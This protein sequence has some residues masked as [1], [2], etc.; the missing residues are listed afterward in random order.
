MKKISTIF[1]LLA[2]FGNSFGQVFLTSQKRVNDKSDIQS[3]GVLDISGSI[4]SSNYY[5]KG[6]TL[7]LIFTLNVNSPDQEYVDQIVMT[8]PQGVKPNSGTDPFPGVDSQANPENLSIN[9]QKVTWGDNDNSYGGI[10]AP[11]NYSFFVNVTVDTNIVGTIEI[12]YSVSGDQYK[13]TIHKFTGIVKVK[14]LPETAELKTTITGFISE[15]YQV[16]LEQATFAP[17]AQILNIGNTLSDTITFF[18][19]ADSEYADSTIINF[20]INTSDTKEFAFSDFTA[21]KKGDVT[22]TFSNNYTK[23]ANPSVKPVEKTINVDNILARDNGDI[24]GHTGIGSEGGE[25]G[26]VFTITKQDTLTAVQFALGTRATLGNVIS[27]KVRSFENG[28]P[29][30]EIGKSLPIKIVE[31]TMYNAGIFPAVVLAPGKYYIGVVEGEKNINIATTSTSFVPHTAWAYFQDKWNDVGDLGFHHTYY[32][33]GVFDNYKEV[34]NDIKLESIDMKEGYAVGNIDII[35][36]I[37]NLSNV[38]ALNEFDIDYTI[39]GGSKVSYHVSGLSLNPGETYSFKHG[40]PYDATTGSHEVSVSISKPNGNDDENKEDNKLI[41]DFMVVNEVFTKV[42]VG[43][44]ATG[45]WCGWCVRGHVGLKD[46]EHN[47]SSDKWIGIAVHN[48]DPMVNDVYDGKIS[49]FV[50]HS[51]PSGAINREFIADPGAFEDTYQEIKDE[52]PVAKIEISKATFDTDTRNIYVAASSI[53]ALDLENTNY[54]LSMVVIEDGIT[55]SGNGY[56]QANYYSSNGITIKDWEGI[57][58]SKLGNPIPANKMVYNHVGRYLVG[59]WDGI[60]GSV[61]STLKYN[62]KNEYNFVSKLPAAYDENNI[63]VAVLLLDN[64]T[65]KILNAAEAEIEITTGTTTIGNPADINIYPNPTKDYITINAKK[66]AKISIYNTNG[67]IILKSEMTEDNKT[68]SLSN[69]A[70]GNYFV[71]IFNN[72]KVYSKKIVIIK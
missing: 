11:G 25:I 31:D 36:T 22:F 66:G 23:D 28:Q 9:G 10:S 46:M 8:F 56:A 16:P 59:G 57:D 47:Y 21:S 48:G 2:L 3:R 1:I 5:I 52:V 18:A 43:E 14:P 41:K 63:S 65:G 24:I 44:E 19:K 32:I 45:T 53:A 58:W 68:L 51:Y 67:Q 20:P 61:P 62:E 72:K 64:K 26:H 6:Q 15:Y 69:L 29:G 35:G 27:V 30:A 39:D 17:T 4:E 33:R 60:Q 54:R 55:G 40:T 71:E 42:I 12:P 49:D 37:R 13:G 70:K 38:N 7:D 50:G 34:Q